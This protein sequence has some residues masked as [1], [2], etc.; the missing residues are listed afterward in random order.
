MSWKARAHGGLG[1][2]IW[3]AGSSQPEL[4]AELVALKRRERRDR[5]KIK[6]GLDHGQA[7]TWDDVTLEM[8]AADDSGG[9]RVCD[10]GAL[11]IPHHTARYCSAKCQANARR[12]KRLQ[13]KCAN[14]NGPIAPHATSRKTRRFCTVACKQQDY[15]KR[16]K[17]KN[18]TLTAQQPNPSMG[19]MKVESGKS[20]T[21]APPISPGSPQK[22]LIKVIPL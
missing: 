11:F 18:V 20:V 13:I 19:N 9:Y 14:C 22:T 5:Y 12:P 8:L 17:A 15:R 2:L 6:R 3:A 1:S 10:C 16:R 4:K 7:A 21:E